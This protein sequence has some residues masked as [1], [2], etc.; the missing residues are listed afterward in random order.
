[1]GLVINSYT[2]YEAASQ[3]PAVDLWEHARANKKIS[4]ILLSPEQL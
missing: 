4:I 2:M 3:D 1:V